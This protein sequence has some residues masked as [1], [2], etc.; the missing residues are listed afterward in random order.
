[1][2]N[3]FSPKHR[4]ELRVHDF[5]DLAAWQP[6]IPVSLLVFVP[7]FDQPDTVL[8]VDDRHYGARLVGRVAARAVKRPAIVIADFTSSYGFEMSEPLA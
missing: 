7:G 1:M 3:S 2:G 6:G 8:D 5:A 4:I